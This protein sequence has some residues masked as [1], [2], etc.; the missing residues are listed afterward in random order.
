MNMNEVNV[1]CVT[2]DCDVLTGESIPE[3]LL[4]YAL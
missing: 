4:A 2:F 1:T 3:F